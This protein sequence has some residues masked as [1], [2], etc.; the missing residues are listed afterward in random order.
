MQAAFHNLSLG[1]PA[2]FAGCNYRTKSSFAVSGD[3]ANIL[4]EID[5]LLVE[6][7]R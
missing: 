4:F 7:A 1:E 5:F 2:P 6:L 3:R